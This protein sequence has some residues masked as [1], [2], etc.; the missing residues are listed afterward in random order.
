MLFPPVLRLPCLLLLVVSAACAHDIRK[1]NRDPLLAEV[2]F[3]QWL[4]QPEQTHIRWTTSISEPGLSAHQRLTARLF[5]QVDGHELA[6]RRGTGKL[7]VLVQISDRQGRVWQDHQEMDLEHV[8]DGIKANDAVFSEIFFVLPGD[9][10][11]D[12]AL[13]FPA[14]QEH[15]LSKRHLHVSPL[16]N[17]PLTDAWRDLP[18]I[19]FIEPSMPPEAWILPAV[20]THLNLS[21]KRQEPVH[22][23]LMVNLTPSER[24]SGSSRVQNRNLSSLL[25]AAKIFANIDWGDS[26]FSLELLDLARRRIAYQQEDAA[27]LDWQE[28]TE[29]LAGVRPG[30]I[31]V[32]ELQNRWYMAQ[33]F[34]DEVVRQIN[35]AP[36][37]KA[38]VILSSAVEF[39]GGQ[40]FRPLPTDLPK[41]TAVFYVR[42]QPLIY[43][44]Q[45]R[46]RGMA[47]P[48]FPPIDQLAGLL[49]PLEPRVFDVATP[50]QFRKALATIVGEIEKL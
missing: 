36:R 42:Y 38:L 29:S 31:N 45:G 40:E 26:R 39:Q 7:L 30:V 23:G 15:A 5:A 41:N 12:T 2:P 17:D 46:G 1:G 24:L 44:P 4:N 9:Y 21:V 49:K 6:K 22:L 47:R 13:Y 20:R 43:G 35:R 25:P 3:D 37:Q 18:A 8:E 14:T 11:V 16:K 33:F 10:H 32:T 27:A 48:V 19:E 34:L 50:E 28:A